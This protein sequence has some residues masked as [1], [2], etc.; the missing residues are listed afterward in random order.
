MAD[1]QLF[2]VSLKLLMKNEQG[3]TLLMK[4]IPTS[5]IKGFYD[6][7]GGR[8]DQD[9]M[10]LDLS[11]IIARETKE[12]LGDAVQYTLRSHKPVAVARHNFWSK[13]TGAEV[14][15]LQV[16]FEAD[17]EGGEIAISP[18]HSGYE[19]VTLTKDNYEQYFTRG[20]RAGV[21]NYFGD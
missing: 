12:E 17:Y 4:S 2:H 21:Q 14:W 16:Y 11:E 9:E 20:F 3:E 7:P 19:W 5:S 10:E 8:I 1:I 15:A 18:E 6:L 13:R